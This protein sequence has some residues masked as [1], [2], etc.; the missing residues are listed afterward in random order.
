MTR[1]VSHPEGRKG[2]HCG[3]GSGRGPL[4][5]RGLPE[6][7]R[8]ATARGWGEGGCEGRGALTHSGGAAALVAVGEQLVQDHPKAP[9]IRLAR[10]DVVREGLR[11]VPGGDRAALGCERGAEDRRGAALGSGSCPGQLGYRRVRL[12][13]QGLSSPESMA[14]QGGT[15]ERGG[16]G[17]NSVACSCGDGRGQCRGRGAQP[18]HW[19][20]RSPGGARAGGVE[21]ARTVRR[22]GRIRTVGGREG[23]G[24]WRGEAG[25][26][27][28]LR[29]QLQLWAGPA[30][31]EEGRG[32]G[33]KGLGEEGRGAS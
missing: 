19:E 25:T 27:A 10:E 20:G 7:R 24:W 31:W 14:S 28:G 33:G 17:V 1:G 30:P 3:W 6:G 16:W 2:S 23:P 5:C 9:D 21:G 22:R 8:S 4:C 11:G 12:Q 18:V 13:L 29:V 15:W 32:L 26:R